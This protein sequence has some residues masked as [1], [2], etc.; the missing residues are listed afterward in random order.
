LLDIL[1]SKRIDPACRSGAAS[2][3]VPSNTNGASANRNTTMKVMVIVKATKNSEAGTAPREEVAKM[4]AEMSAFNEELAKAGVL[5]TADGLQPSAKGKRIRLSGRSRTVIDGPFTETKEL[6]AGYWVWQVRSIDE[7]IEWARRCPD[8]HPGE[9]GELEIRPMHVL[10]DHCLEEVEQRSPS[11]PITI[12]AFEAS[13]DRGQGLAR[14]TRVRWALEEVGQPYGVRLVSFRAMKEP[15]HLALHP[16]GQIPTY[17]EGDLALFETGAIVLHLAERHPGL[18]PVDANAR[19]RAI[20]WMIAALNTVEPPI[21][22]L[23]TA[24]LLECDKPWYAARL[25]LLQDRVRSRLAQL[26]VRL[27]DTD[28]LDG[29]FSAADLMMVSVLLRLRSSGLLDEFPNLA[30]YVARGEARSAYQRAF[31]AQLA[32]YTGKP[33]AG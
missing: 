25:P 9:D 24:N 32:V 21:L 1:R 23:V 3:V 26:S 19:A 8:P 6:I 5:V 15:A 31:A 14:D 27:G 17:E 16:F 28:W 11:V 7:A 12:T 30:A 20:T 2:F 18:L 33:S 13:P 4:L 10:D 29:A 22:E